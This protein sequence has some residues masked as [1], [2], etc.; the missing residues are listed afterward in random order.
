M[1]TTSHNDQ[2]KPN[3]ES[4]AADFQL[5]MCL[6]RIG[7]ILYY[8]CSDPRH[9]TIYDCD[10]RVQQYD[11]MPVQMISGFIVQKVFTQVLVSNLDG[12]S[13][14]N[15]KCACNGTRFVF[16]FIV[17]TSQTLAYLWTFVQVAHH[18]SNQTPE[19][20][21][22]RLQPY[23]R[24]ILNGYL[25][26]DQQVYKYSARSWMAILCKKDI[27]NVCEKMNNLES[28]VSIAWKEKF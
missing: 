24:R 13:I 19:Q 26:C 21:I 20:T 8:N 15:W 9:Q 18:L 17:T 3:G 6:F 1:A 28:G 10:S 2:G 25:V 5:Y 27:C 11:I 12:L 16:R 14:L 7:E 4:I 22:C 23:T